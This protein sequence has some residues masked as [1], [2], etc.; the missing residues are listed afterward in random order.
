MSLPRW[1]K[2]VSNSNLDLWLLVPI[3][4]LAFWLG[5]EFISNQVLSR[6]ENV[7]TKLEANQ[8]TQVKLAFTVEEIQVLINKNTEL[9]KVNVKTNDSELKRLEFEFNIIDFRALEGK[10]AQ[11][12]SL[13][14]K[15]VKRLARYELEN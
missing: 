7:I 13:S 6:P 12:L 3:L 8:P 10:I 5:G 11:E 15:D 14:P 4:A 2:K 1:L 9:T